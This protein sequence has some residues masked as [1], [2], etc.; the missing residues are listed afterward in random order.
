MGPAREEG[1]ADQSLPSVIEACRNLLTTDD[2]ALEK[3]ESALV[4]ARYSP[5]HADEYEKMRFRII[6]EVLFEV[7]KEFP[8]I[9]VR[10]F[11]G[12]IPDG[13]ERVEYEINL[14]G[15]IRAYNNKLI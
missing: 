13:I 8:R 1:G 14:N 5:H 3:F 12:G 15:Y 9:S 2:D 7:T 11:V 10:N 6:E 4:Q